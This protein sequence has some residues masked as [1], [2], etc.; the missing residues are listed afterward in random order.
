MTFYLPNTNGWR[1][2]QFLNFTKSLREDVL[3][4]KSMKLPKKAKVLCSSV[5]ED[6]DAI[7]ELM[8]K[9]QLTK[10]VHTRATEL[11]NWALLKATD[12]PIVSLER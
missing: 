8:T 11:A 6:L 1:K 5:L 4:M 3:K 9:K 7:D 10:R 12:V 2:T